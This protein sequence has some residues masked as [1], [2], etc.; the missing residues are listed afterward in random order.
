VLKVAVVVNIFPFC[1]HNLFVYVFV[2]VEL[3]CAVLESAHE[4]IALSDTMAQA[5]DTLVITH[6]LKL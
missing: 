5:K 2:F 1:V 3:Y 4:K 6:S